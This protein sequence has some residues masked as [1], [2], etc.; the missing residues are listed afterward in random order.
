MDK[1]MRNEA[2]KQYLKYFK[3]WFIV[4][5]ILFV[6]SIVCA[7][8]RNASVQNERT[9][10]QAPKERV[11]DQADVLSSSEEDALRDLIEQIEDQISAD[12]V[13]VTTNLNMLGTGSSFEDSWEWNMQKTADDFYDNNS[14]G[15]NAPQGDGVLILDNWYEGQSG[16][17]LS[18]C[19][20]MVG[21]FGDYEVNRVLDEIYYGIEYGH[22]AYEAYAEA[23]MLI[24]RM[25][26]G[27]KNVIDKG[28][29]FLGAFI[30]STIAAL[31]YVFSKL[32]NK[33]GEKTTVASTYVEGSPAMNI[34]QDQFIRRVVTRRKI[35]KQNPSA[36]SAGRSGSGGGGVHR[37]SS[38]VRHGGGGRRR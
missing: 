18:T 1:E 23:I 14:F 4:V 19:G 12:I 5:G 8:A 34:Q 2:V 20:K 38:G 15:Y 22:G 32:S 10:T 26:G 21:L 28:T 13:L 9:N 30:V 6:I 3:I 25:F 36:G 33:D 17:W 37:S 24:G 27:E 16:S 35:P 29:Y 7:I 11:Y 31:I